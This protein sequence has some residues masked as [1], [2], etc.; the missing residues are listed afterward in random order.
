MYASLVET[1][2][3]LPIEEKYS[4]STIQMCLDR[5]KKIL[6]KGATD[7]QERLVGRVVE[8]E[9]SSWED[10]IDE[11][12]ITDYPYLETFDML[13]GK[14]KRERARQ[15]NTATLAALL[16]LILLSRHGTQKQFNYEQRSLLSQPCQ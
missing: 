6:I 11:E 13:S 9:F 16:W 1:N 12:S 5:D 10:N 3:A 8:S 15:S 7:P 4:D 14:E 2:K